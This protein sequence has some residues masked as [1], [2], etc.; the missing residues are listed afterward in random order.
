MKDHIIALHMRLIVL[1]YDEPQI[2][3]HELATCVEVMAQDLR[4]NHNSV[5]EEGVEASSPAARV[6]RALPIPA[7]HSR[8]TDERTLAR[9]LR[10]GSSQ[11]KDVEWKNRESQVELRSVA[12][13]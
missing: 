10:N 3:G 1:S 2:G 7:K 11:S 8:I 6:A 5:S 12:T 9:F 13:T 4:Q